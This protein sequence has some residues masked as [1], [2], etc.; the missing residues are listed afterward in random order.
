MA[1]V[2]FT[3]EEFQFLINVFNRPNISPLQEDAI[4]VI[5]RVRG[6]MRKVEAHLEIE[7]SSPI[8]C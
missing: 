8:E 4:P 6:I 3:K 5:E 1:D 7:E 2:K